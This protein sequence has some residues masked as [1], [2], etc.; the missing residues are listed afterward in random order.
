[1]VYKSKTTQNEIIDICRNL[2]T[3]KITDENR[4]IMFFTEEA[5]DVAT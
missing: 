4:E 3:K 5:A 1:M 2:L